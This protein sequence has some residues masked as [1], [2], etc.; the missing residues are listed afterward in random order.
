[1]GNK[2]DFDEDKL[3]YE[4]GNATKLSSVIQHVDTSKIIPV[5]AEILNQRI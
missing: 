1:L 5:V 2:G 3:E 4:F